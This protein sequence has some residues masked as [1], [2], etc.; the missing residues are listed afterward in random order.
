MLDLYNRLPV[1]PN[2]P[3]DVE[4]YAPDG[5]HLNDAGHR[6]LA[7]LLKDFLKAL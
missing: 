3:E 2:R 7:Q 5:L 4:K 1:D 6:M